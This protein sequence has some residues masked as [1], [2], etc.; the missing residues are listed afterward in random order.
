[1]LNNFLATICKSDERKK[2]EK[3][4]ESS[5]TDG[6]ACLAWYVA[7]LAGTRR[8]L[9]WV[10]APPFS[11]HP[12]QPASHRVMVQEYFIGGVLHMPCT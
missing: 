9:T 4:K 11:Y 8:R 12:R 2:E 6:I 7:K 5:S 1:M 10:S 3:S